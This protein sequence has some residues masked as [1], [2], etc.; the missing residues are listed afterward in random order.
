MSGA[1]VVSSW[2]QATASAG[3]PDRCAN[4]QRTAA[5]ASSCAQASNS[6]RAAPEPA[7]AASRLIVHG[8]TASPIFAVG[9]PKTAPGAATRRSAARAS[10]VPAPIAGPF[11]AAS[12]GT[13]ASATACSIA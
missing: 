4:P 7:S 8:S 11:T 6:S 12:T 10:W 13:G 1:S 2:A 3:S 9:T 5:P